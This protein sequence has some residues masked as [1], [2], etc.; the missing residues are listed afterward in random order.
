MSPYEALANAIIIQAVNDYR[1]AGKNIDKGREIEASVTE[2]KLVV[3]FINSKWFTVLT[4]VRP[5]IL[6]KKLKQEGF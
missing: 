2:R 4:E 1:S 3:E 6:L 5:E